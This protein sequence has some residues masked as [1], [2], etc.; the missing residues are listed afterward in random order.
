MCLYKEFQG[1]IS[2]LATREKQRKF[3]VYLDPLGNNVLGMCKELL[4]WTDEQYW[5]HPDCC[6]TMSN[7]GS[8]F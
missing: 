5:W 1:E 8:T 6:G 7:T 2:G 4:V 3:S